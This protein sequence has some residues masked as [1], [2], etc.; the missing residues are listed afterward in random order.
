MKNSI[1]T[2]QIIVIGKENTKTKMNM[3][4]RYRNRIRIR[5]MRVRIDI[6]IKKLEKWSNRQE[7]L[8]MKVM[9]NNKFTINITTPSFN[10]S[11]KSSMV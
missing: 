3:I 11:N 1:I 2:N 6:R 10:N 5:D 4:F 7:K 8:N 9:K